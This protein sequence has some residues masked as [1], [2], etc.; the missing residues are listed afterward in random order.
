MLKTIKRLIR[1]RKAVSPVIATILLIALT[2]TSVTVVYFLIIPYL[3]RTQLDAF[4]LKVKDSDKDSKYDQITLYVSNFGTKELEIN[5]ITI[6]TVPEGL[7]GDSNY[8]S[9]H[10]NWT[11]VKAADAYLAPSEIT[12][13]VITG[14]EQIILTAYENTY[15]R[16]EILYTGAPDP[17]FTDWK[18]LN[19]QADFSDLLADF[20]SFDLQAWGL[21]GTIDVPG[22][23]SNNYKTL[24][25]PEHGPLVADQS[26]YLPVIGE[27]KYVPFYFTGKIV[28][29]HSTNGNLTGQPTMQQIDRTSNPFKAKKLFLLGLAGSWG[30]EFPVGATALTLNVTYT[31]G[32]SS[33]WNLGHEY[34]DDWWK[35]SNSN[36][37]PTYIS[38]CI[39][40]PYGM[41]TEIDLGHQ[42][43]SPYEPIHTHTAGFSLDFYKYISYITF[44]DPGNDQSGPHLLSLTAG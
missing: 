14:T 22:W 27:A 2:V 38:E 43:D 1:R 32:S 30:D 6:Y 33:I 24:G 34:I 37:S 31:D 19:D 8:Y 25:G 39:S 20:E 41:I 7:I 9:I 17:Y 15:Y 44:V 40:A 36:H 42:I 10:N 13:A 4:V 12:N 16:L 3:N 11:F 29:F 35:D 21:S 23:V 26:I 18:I 5:K 28:I